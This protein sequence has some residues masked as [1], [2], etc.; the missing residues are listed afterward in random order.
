MS[1]TAVV[2]DDDVLEPTLQC[3]LDHKT[4]RWIFVGGKG[5]VGKTTTSCSLAIQLSKV[6]KSVLLISTDPAH[7]LSDAFGQKFGK[8]ARLID[9][10]DNLSAMEID[11]NGSIQD[12]M[13]SGGGDGND[14]AMGGFGLGGMMQD[15]AFSIPG[16]DEAMSFAEVLKQVKSLSY[17]VIVFDT[18]P[19]G[20]TLRFLQFP[21]VLEKALSKLSQLSG[22][23]GPMLNSVLGARGGLPGGQNLDDVLSKME[24]LRETIAEVNSQF[25][26]ADMTTFVCVCIAEFLSLYETERMIQELTSYNI[27]THCIVVNQLLFP[28]KDNACQ[29]CGARRK[30]Q[31]KYLNEIKELYEDFNVVRMPLLVEE[32]RGREKLEK[33]FTGKENYTGLVVIEEGVISPLKKERERRNNYKPNQVKRVIRLIFTMVDYDALLKG[34]WMELE[35]RM[36][37][38]GHIHKY[39][40]PAQNKLDPSTHN[41]NPQTVERQRIDNSMKLLRII[42]LSPSYQDPAGGHLLEIPKSGTCLAF[43]VNMDNGWPAME[44]R[45]VSL[46]SFSHKSTATVPSKRTR[47]LGSIRSLLR[48]GS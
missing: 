7:N 25:K 42:A 14:D 47:T 22:Q 26:D 3:L 18:A 28:G 41:V 27:D 48:D 39:I 34:P 24:S 23:F 37:A 8:E 43:V 31:K 46:S 45:V 11:P 15:L 6:R 19:T 40:R 16:V 21:T 13:A 5:G 20:H 4:L 2:G 44:H 38:Q 36:E 1:S 10:Y 32:V 35:E 9:G 12:L 29:Q 33:K 30:M 17:E